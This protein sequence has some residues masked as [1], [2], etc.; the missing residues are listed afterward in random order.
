MSMTMDLKPC[1]FC[2]GEAESDSQRGYRNIST[3]NPENAAAIYCTKCS[4]DMTWCY[5]DTPEIE[6]NHVMKLLIEQWNTRATASLQ[7][8]DAVE[9]VARIMV[10][11][12][13]NYCIYHMPGDTPR[14][15]KAT[16]GYRGKTSELSESAAES[17]RV[18]ARA[19]LATGLVPDEAT[20]RGDWHTTGWDRARN[21]GR[22]LLVWREF[23]GVREHVEL[24]RYSDSKIAWVN[25]Y[26][27][28]FHVEPDG[29]APLLPF[30]TAETIR[31]D[32]R[33]RCAKVAEAEYADKNWHAMYRHAAGA[34]AA[35]IRSGGGE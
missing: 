15:W 6:R 18:R 29:W 30:K 23:A 19:I 21:S 7:C 33:E 13:P 24:G 26:G 25:T 32:E 9:R 3:G 28:P 34:I 8:E 1:P 5:R 17:V 27:H 31:A 14:D 11:T 20:I 22:I 12:D 10:R 2:G 16:S 4:A 35:A